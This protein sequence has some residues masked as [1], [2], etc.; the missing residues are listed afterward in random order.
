MVDPSLFAA[1][2]KT[3][4]ELAPLPAGSQPPASP[5][6]QRAAAEAAEKARQNTLT[7]GFSFQ[8]LKDFVFGPPPKPPRI[9]G[10]VFNQDAYSPFRPDYNPN[11][12]LIDQLGGPVASFPKV[13]P[14]ARPS[15]AVTENT[16]IEAPPADGPLIL[17]PTTPPARAPRSGPAKIVPNITRPPVATMVERA[18]QPTGDKPTGDKPTGASSYIAQLMSMIKDLSPEAR[19]ALLFGGGGALAGGLYGLMEPGEETVYDEMGRPSGKRRKSR[20][21]AALR[22]AAIAGGLSAGAGGAYGAYSR[23]A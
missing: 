8:G 4:F 1:A 3:A 14:P 6:A 19:N 10:D 5:P 2:H 7:P 9:P 12:L 15:T 20:L 13:Q 23:Q 11:S 21:L 16:R 17:P 18:Q 22:N